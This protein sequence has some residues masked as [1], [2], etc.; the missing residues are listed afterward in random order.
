M[1]VD[2]V[3]KSLNASYLILLH[4]AKCY[5]KK[6]S[7]YKEIPFDGFSDF[8]LSRSLSL[9]LTGQIAF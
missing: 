8:S 9:L 5:I 7:L 3:G 4:H 2:A 6:E 1:R